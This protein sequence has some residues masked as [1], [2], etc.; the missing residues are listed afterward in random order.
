M[1]IRTVEQLKHPLFQFWE[2]VGYHNTSYRSEINIACRNKKRFTDFSVPIQEMVLH[3]VRYYSNLEVILSFHSSKSLAMDYYREHLSKDYHLWGIKQMDF[4]TED[5]KDMIH[6][7]MYQILTPRKKS[8]RYI[9]EHYTWDEKE[10]NFEAEGKDPKVCVF[11]YLLCK[12]RLETDFWSDKTARIFAPTSVEE[13]HIAASIVFN[14][15]SWNMIRL[16]NFDYLNTSEMSASKEK[17]DLYREW[18]SRYIAVEKQ[19]FFMLYSSVLFYILGHREMNDID[20][21]IH[22]VPNDETEET[23]RNTMEDIVNETLTLLFMDYSMKNTAKWPRYWNKW[24]DE[25]ARLCGAKYFEDILCN[26][27]YHFY[28]MGVKVI[29]LHCDIK[30]RIYRNRPRAI[31]DL[32]SLRKRYGIPMVL[33]H[34]PREMN[35]YVD[36]SEKTSEEIA[37]MLKEDCKYNHT[38][39]EIVYIKSVDETQFLKTVQWALKERYHMSFSIPEILHELEMT[40]SSRKKEEMSERRETSDELLEPIV[41]PQ[42][43]SIKIRIK[44]K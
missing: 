6:K 39:Q 32:I 3:A 42:K 25:W 34:V 1:I 14:D 36:V 27:V 18:F 17:F 33:P 9:R 41:K 19:P 26:P 7:M 28:Y 29:S 8:K 40:G 31:A 13:R 43:K 5:R 11:V 2:K 22:S 35:E 10:E 30:R 20:L 15:E 38:F 37:V 23:E 4:P 44:K 24:L 21:Y 16:Q 12:R